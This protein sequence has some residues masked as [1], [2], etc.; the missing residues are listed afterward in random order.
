MGALLHLRK[1]PCLGVGVGDEDEVSGIFSEE[2][3][4]GPKR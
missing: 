4:L 1:G 3:S 2:E